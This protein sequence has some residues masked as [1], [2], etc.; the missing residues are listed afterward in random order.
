MKKKLSLVLTLALCVVLIFS[1]AAVSLAADD[2]AAPVSALDAEYKFYATNYDWGEEVDSIEFTTAVE[3]DPATVSV[4]DFKVSSSGWFG[5][6]VR[7]LSNL[8]VEGKT[9]KFDTSITGSAVNSNHENTYKIALIGTVADKD[10][11]EYNALNLTYTG[12]VN[13]AIDQLGYGKTE[14][15]NYRYYEPA[16]AGDKALPL[17]IWLHGGGEFGDDN[18]IHLACAAATNY[19]KPEIQQIFGGAAYVLYP[20]SPAPKPHI[21][22]NVMEAVNDFI[23]KFNVDTNRIYIMGC[24]QGGKTTNELISEYPDF[25]TAAISDCPY[26]SQVTEEAAK[27]LTDFPII[28]VHALNDT[29]AMPYESI[30]SYNHLR[31]AG[32]DQAYCCFFNVVGNN[33]VSGS[34][35]FGHFSWVLLH[36]NFTTT[37]DNFING[38]GVYTR[39][40]VDYPYVSTPLSEIGKGYP[41]IMSWLADQNK[42]GTIDGT[43]DVYT[44]SHPYGEEATT[45]VID[46]GVAMDA[47]TITPDDFT[48][49]IQAGMC[50]Y[51]W[52]T[53]RT[54]DSVEVDGSKITLNLVM[55]GS[56]NNA[57]VGDNFKV[58]LAGY[59]SDAEGNEYGSAEF[60]LGQQINPEIDQMIAVAH[61]NEGV[62]YR[63]FVPE[64]EPE[65]A[66]LYI[67][68][69]GAG[70]FGS[71]NRSQVSCSNLTDWLKPE[72]Q[73]IF[74]EDGL[75]VM[76]IQSQRSPHN[77][78][79][80]MNAILEVTTKYNIDM[81]RIYIAGCSAGGMGVNTM[82]TAFPNFFAAAA[83]NCAASVI[84]EA[85]GATLK[86][87][88]VIFVHAANDGTVALSNSI[89]SY[90]NMKAAGC[91][92]VWL[93]FFTGNG[94]NPYTGNG[95]DGHWSWIWIHSNYTSTEPEF[96]NGEGTYTNRGTEYTYVSTP[97]SEIDGGYAT[98][99]NWFAA[100][101][102]T[103]VIAAGTVEAQQ[104]DEILIPITVN[105]N[106]GIS[107]VTIQMNP[108]QY[109]LVDVVEGE[110]ATRTDALEINVDN[111]K[112]IWTGEAG[113]GV[114]FYVKATVENP[115]PD[116]KY[117]I[118]IDLL[119][120]TG[121]DAEA[122][123]ATTS[124]GMLW[125]VNPHPLGDVSLDG[126]INNADVI[127]IA[128]YLIDLVQFDEEQ[129]EKADYDQN[130]EIN[131]TDLVK[132][133]RYLV[134]E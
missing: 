10:G 59:I 26:R 79:R 6:T 133:A 58:N 83:P 43:F 111:G 14:H 1:L 126:S 22:S 90:N 85:Q 50:G 65:G 68:L 61:K 37:E 52:T 56:G 70:E 98:I 11:K 91:D 93:N 2:E 128:R 124:D 115:T 62:Q 108:V 71:D 54:V 81:S 86:D 46:T 40:G 127:M 114:L 48:I 113:D 55:T 100:Q 107:S 38:T 57:P 15:E 31:A 99:A 78:N 122:T 77:A 96:I 116:G 39:D 103:N 73:D 34:G 129:L 45:V 30:E 94:T 47:E 117:P 9:V 60:T 95:Y 101:K 66:P 27:N 134:G 82:I 25:F 130:G 69:H 104:G 132:I 32:N 92:K 53:Y 118:L 74:G 123:T 13:P 105:G 80:V 17:I 97:L 102:R 121:D 67:W 21:T 109:T 110:A 35:Y 12:I 112:V 18:R 24:S 42:A 75:Y 41:N 19:T 72:V 8:T 87:L 63:L 4:E 120:V 29:T 44:E 28:Y 7:T 89:R 125:I 23:D 36:N 76:A 88:P 106:N 49:S 131:N 64:G 119:A 3:L 5:E 84:S 16:N 51:T 20:Q 33:P